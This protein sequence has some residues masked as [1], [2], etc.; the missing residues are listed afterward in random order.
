[1][2]WFHPDPAIVLINPKLF[3]QLYGELI[4]SRANTRSPWEVMRPGQEKGLTIADLAVTDG[5]STASASSFSASYVEATQEAEVASNIETVTDEIETNLAV[6]FAQVEVK[7]NAV[8]AAMKRAGVMAQISQA[9]GTDTLALADSADWQVVD[10]SERTVTSARAYP[11]RITLPNISSDGA[12][13]TVPP[14][15]DV[16]VSA[17]SSGPIFV[18]D[19]NHKMVGVV[20]PYT[21][22]TFKAIYVA[23]NSRWADLGTTSESNAKAPWSIIAPLAVTLPTAGATTCNLAASYTDA[24]WNTAVSLSI[25]TAFNGFD[26]TLAAAFAQVETTINAII[27]AL[28]GMDIVA[29]A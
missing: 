2:G 17:N 9:E 11:T 29:D 8:I 7:V 27:T 20:Q 25:N 14:Y 22:K 12:T 21:S 26:T 15:H 18:R 4:G 28:E 13:T 5:A 6:S 3:V 1:M 24:N 19:F 23:S 16:R 10:D